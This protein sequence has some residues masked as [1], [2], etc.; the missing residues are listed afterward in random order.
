MPKAF[1]N[2]PSAYSR[3]SVV[4][5]R[6]VSCPE[7]TLTVKRKVD[8]HT[9]LPTSLI[10]FVEFLLLDLFFYLPLLPCTVE[11]DAF[12]NLVQ[13]SVPFQSTRVGL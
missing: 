10:S 7:I 3:M 2:L 4:K 12:D 5:A 11:K 9:M 8:H 6:G 1:I 13:A